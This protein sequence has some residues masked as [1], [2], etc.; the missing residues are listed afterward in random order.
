MKIKQLALA[1]ASLGCVMTAFPG[2]AQAGELD[3]MKA[4]L[5]KLQARI[6]TL[7]AQ[8]A[9]A[10]AP[11]ATTSVTAGNPSL[12]AN[13]SV[14]LYGKLDVFTEYDT[15]G[16][17]GTRLAFD[18]GGMNG[19]RWGVKGGA[20]LTKEI[21]GIYQVEGGFLVNKGSSTQGGLLFGRQAYVGVEGKFGRV[22][23]GRQYGV[24]Y[25]ATQAYD[26]F[27]QGYGSPTNSGQFDSGAVR[28]D[29]SL[30]YASPKFGDFSGNVM[31]S[32]ANQ[33]GGDKHTAHALAL[34]YAPGKFGATLATQKDDH[35]ADATAV[36]N[37]KFAG[38]SYQLGNSKL[39]VGL[40]RTDRTVDG[41]S[42]THRKEWMVG[43]KSQM[44][45]SGALL[46]ILSRG[47]TSEL[48]DASGALAVGWIEALSPQTNVY[49]VLARHTNGKVAAN[50][51]Q[52]TSSSGA[53]SINPGQ[54]PYGLALGFQYSF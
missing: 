38:A 52:G 27:E 44:T 16:G 24:F 33:T 29:T 47:K 17:K 34:N 21:R 7:E 32:N 12:F 40:N 6:D 4:M 10:P 28:Y 13:S 25:N 41:A 8:K 45:S 37:Y 53:Y 2:A 22:T 19:S 48:D 35:I 31:V 46:A 26:P 18:S 50:V 23:T 30:I 9:A 42:M 39:M 54:D 14:T 15:G 20:D 49:G 3:E 51:P 36:K 1:V 11:A 43:V 5:Q